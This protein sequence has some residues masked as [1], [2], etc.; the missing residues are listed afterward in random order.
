[1]TRAHWL[2]LQHVALAVG[3]VLAC[4]GVARALAWFRWR[5]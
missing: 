2:D 4:V 1:M 3:V 5:E